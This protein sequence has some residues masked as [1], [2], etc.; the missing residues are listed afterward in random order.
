MLSYGKEIIKFSLS[1]SLLQLFFDDD[2]DESDEMLIQGWQEDFPL[3]ALSPLF[4]L[5]L[6]LDNLAEKKVLE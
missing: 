4:P 1:L 5:S 6:S 2:S 3:S